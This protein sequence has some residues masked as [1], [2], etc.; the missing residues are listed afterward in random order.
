[1]SVSVHGAADAFAVE[2]VGCFVRDGGFFFQV[3][4]GATGI[5]GNA[6][7]G[8][9]T[10]DTLDAGEESFVTVGNRFEQKP[11]DGFFVGS[12]LA[13]DHFADD[14]AAIAVL[15]GG[16]GEMATDRFAA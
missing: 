11:W 9:Q 5:W 6:A 10:L 15:P 2:I 16:T 14:L 4:C 12:R 8:G 7:F 1:M 3:R 13:G